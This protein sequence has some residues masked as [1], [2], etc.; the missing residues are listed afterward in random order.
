MNRCTE[1]AK[2]YLEPGNDLRSSVVAFDSWLTQIERTMKDAEKP[3]D[4]TN[5][6]SMSP[7]AVNPTNGLS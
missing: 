4:G 5:E 3:L 1:M 7:G 2:V 6:R